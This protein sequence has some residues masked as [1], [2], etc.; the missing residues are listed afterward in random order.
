MKTFIIAIVATFLAI[1][2]GNIEYVYDTGLGW[3]TVVAL[4]IL[5]TLAWSIFVIRTVV[6][7]GTTSRKLTLLFQKAIRG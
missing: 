1:I 5:A 7:K 6:G 4:S 2:G 3:N